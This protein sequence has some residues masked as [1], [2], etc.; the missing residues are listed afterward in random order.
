MPV[1]E[2]VAELLAPIIATLG[3]ELIDV[4][5]IGS[6]LRV[7]VDEDSGITTDRL[8]EVNRLISPI[9][10]QHD[11]VPGRYTLEVSSPGVERKLVRPDHFRRAIDED[12]V[13]KL[14]PGV[15]PRRVKGRLVSY[16]DEIV[17]VDAIEVDGVD[18]AEPEPFRI[19]LHDIAKAR[20][21]FA[22]GP[23]PKPGGKKSNVTRAPSKKAA[24]KQ[25]QKKQTPKG[26][27]PE[28]SAANT[29]TSGPAGH[30]GAA[31]S[32]QSS[33]RSEAARHE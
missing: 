23:A 2:T 10:D 16:A 24:K 32:N 12:V 13:V 30:G 3:V 14:Q 28:P 33:T 4:E 29:E 7:V 6:S 1:A 17:G 20:T 5:W 18:L 27:A 21:V 25:A 31:T 9:L 19:P 8:A 15:E 22:W 26:A 11:P